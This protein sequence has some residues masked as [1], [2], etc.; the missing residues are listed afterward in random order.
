[1][2]NL[3]LKELEKNLNNLKVSVVNGSYS[4]K[5]ATIEFNKIMFAAN[6]LLRALKK[7]ELTNENVAKD[8]ASVIE[9]NAKLSELK[10]KYQE[11]FNDVDLV[12]DMTEDLKS[13]L[14]DRIHTDSEDELEV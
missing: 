8:I 1:M 4:D 9:F 12:E 3:I 7:K 14:P 13:H 5:Q 6:T 11:I 2:T 10:N